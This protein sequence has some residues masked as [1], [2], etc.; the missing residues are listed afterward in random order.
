MTTKVTKELLADDS[1]GTDQIINDSVTAD[2]L[3]D[4]AVGTEHYQIDSVQQQHIAPGAIGWDEI[5]DNAITSP[6]YATNSLPITAIGDGVITGAKLAD[7]TI[8][9]D[10]L[11]TGSVTTP[12]YANASIDAA[13]IK[14]GT[15]TS[16]LYADNSIITQKIQDTAITFA[17][18][19]N[20]TSGN[21]VYYNQSQKVS[22]LNIG[23]EGQVLT[24]SNG[25]PIWSTGSFPTGLLFDYYGN[26]APTGWLEAAGQTIGSASSAADIGYADL[27]ALFKHLWD[28]F[29]DSIATV[30]G[31]RGSTAD[32]D[33]AANKTITLPDLRGRT[34]VGVE[35]NAESL[36][37]RISASTFS[38]G[39]EQVGATGGSETVTLTV[40]Q[41]PEHR[42]HTTVNTEL[43]GITPTSSPNATSTFYRG[44]DAFYSLAYRDNFIL[45]GTGMTS[46]QVTTAGLPPSAYGESHSNMQPSVLVMKV[47]K[48]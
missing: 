9:E 13:K 43:S 24:V 47:I 36:S 4:L 5:A 16:S 32:A 28:S 3:A 42:H 29:P 39:V 44:Y 41:I 27:E 22:T 35:G 33:W 46:S 48:I 17:K 10:Q 15:L 8:G 40:E 12:K 30:A 11:G 25:L 23:L 14:P 31:G 38:A 20:S 6:K 18:L 37:G 19:Q 7:L 1:V 21:L 2:A 45:P 26:S 34:T